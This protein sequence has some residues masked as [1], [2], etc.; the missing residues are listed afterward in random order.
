MATLIQYV[1]G[2]LGFAMTLL[3]VANAI[4]SYRRLSHIPG[5]PFAAFSR[6]WS[7]KSILSTRNHLNIYEANLRYGSLAR[8]G[9]N[10]IV[11][12]DPELIRRMNA[13]RSP[14]RRGP[15]FDAMRFMPEVGNTISE[16]NEERHDELRRKMAAGYSG[17][18][19]PGMESE[20]DKRISELVSLIER[21]YVCTD[22]EP[23]RQMDLAQKVEFFTLDAISG[24]AFGEPFGDLIDDSDKFDYKKT[25]EGSAPVLVLLG[26][27]LE[28]RYF[29]DKTSLMK[30]LAPSATDKTGL[31]RIIGIAAQKVAER[32][33]GGR[34]AKQDM[35]GSFVK[36]GLSKQE[37]ESETVLQL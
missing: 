32:F 1:L 18:E 2:A 13:P 35:L 17:K 31:G 28:V 16:R 12:C 25:L 36:N 27:L 37:A 30:L 24:L 11:T 9:P 5:P 19:N 29:L 34:K 14:Y 3:T 4:R 15:W 7:V 8:I 33:G 20:I 26:E 21:K 10:H 22:E 6:L 23:G